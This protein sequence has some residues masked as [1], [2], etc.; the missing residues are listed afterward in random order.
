MT[1]CNPTSFDETAEDDIDA[2]KHMKLLD[3]AW[4]CGTAMVIR[5]PTIRAAASAHLDS[6]KGKEAEAISQLSK[7]QKRK[8]LKKGK[9]SV[10][11]EHPV[12]MLA[13]EFFA[14]LLAPEEDDSKRCA[15][16]LLNS[17]RV[18]WK[19]CESIR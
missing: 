17:F 6:Y 18:E 12:T 11:V 4:E 16:P 15:N 3:L 8:V 9:R 14:G 5:Y 10:Q 19:I 7:Q 13:R 2:D 1:F